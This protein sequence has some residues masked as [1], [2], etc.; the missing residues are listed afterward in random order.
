MVSV[1]AVLG[2]ALAEGRRLTPA[3]GSR[4]IAG[5]RPEERCH[6]KNVS[7][8]QA[9]PEED[10]RLPRPDENED[11]TRRPR[12]SASQGTQAAVRLKGRTD[13]RPTLA[14]RHM[15]SGKPTGAPLCGGEH[16]PPEKRLRRRWEFL[17]TYRSGRRVHGRFV[18]VFDCPAEGVGPRLGITVT[19]KVGT[20]IV[21]NRLRRQ[22]REIFRRSR[23]ARGAPPCRVVVNVLPRAAAAG[24][25]ELRDE[26]ER[27]LA[28]AAG[29]LA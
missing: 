2:K 12:A 27:L 10:A 17:E 21:R 5:S 15:E 25:F 24:F 29:G 6:E 9:P 13:R 28:G 8:E 19:R 14:I 22:I 4:R 18:L 16:F 1:A 3:R 7:A 20:A 11:W 26:L 23:V